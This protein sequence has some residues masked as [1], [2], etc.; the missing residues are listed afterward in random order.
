MTSC[1]IFVMCFICAVASDEKHTREI[2]QK[3]KSDVGCCSRPLCVISKLLLL[4][5][6]RKER[7]NKK[8]E[9]DAEELYPHMLYLYPYILYLNC[10]L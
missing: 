2:N 6:S 5:R 10:V 3:L 1:V 9:G 7:N 4:R 8:Q